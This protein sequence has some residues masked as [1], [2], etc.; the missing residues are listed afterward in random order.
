GSTGGAA[1][2]PSVRLRSP[3]HAGHSAAPPDRRS[4]PGRLT[5]ACS[6]AAPAARAPAR[7]ARDPATARVS[8]AQPNK[9]D[10]VPRETR[11]TWVRSLARST[12]MEAKSQ[13]QSREAD[14]RHAAIA[15]AQPDR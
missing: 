12:L 14:E 5:T 15:L 2:Q 10:G 3:T 13:G 8:W 1:S 7:S 6:R 9:A 11:E 4:A